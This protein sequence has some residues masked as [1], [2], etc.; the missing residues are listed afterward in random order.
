MDQVAGPRSHPA[1][2]LVP[3]RKPGRYRDSPE[4]QQKNSGAET[5]TGLKN[6][7]LESLHQLTGSVFHVT[8]KSIDIST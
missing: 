2:A 6:P 5:R 1:F 7:V 3:L 8:N 4:K